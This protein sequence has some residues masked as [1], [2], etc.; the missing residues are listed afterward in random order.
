MK[1]EIKVKHNWK[2]RKGDL[3]YSVTNEK[4]ED[5]PLKDETSKIHKFS[6]SGVNVIS[7]PEPPPPEILLLLA[8]L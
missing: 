7:L 4:G 2:K 5:C 3:F 8:R 6:F 1:D